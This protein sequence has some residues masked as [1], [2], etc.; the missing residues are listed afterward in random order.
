MLT[1][2]PTGALMGWPAFLTR[3]AGAGRHRRA[4]PVS[5]DFAVAVATY[6]AARKRWPSTKIT[7]PPGRS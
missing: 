3:A 6:A 2:P 1:P 5:E 4:V 7:P